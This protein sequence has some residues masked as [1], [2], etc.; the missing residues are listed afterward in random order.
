MPNFSDIID[1]RHL[2][3]KNEILTKLDGSEKIKF[4]VGYLYLSGFYQIADKLENLQ[5]VKLLIGSNINR[6]LMEALAESAAGDEELDEQFETTQL[7]RPID[8]D[9]IKENI[10]QSMTA[11]LQAL[12]HT[13][14]RQK[15][16][17]KLVELVKTRKVHIRVYTKHPLHAKAYI[18][19]FQDRIASASASEGIGIIGSSN[20]TMS[21]FFHNTELN[22]YV[23]G[24]KNYEELN[25]WF[26]R[27]WEEGV[28]FE[29]ALKETFEESWALKTVNPYDIFILTLYHLTKTTIER[30]TEQIWFWEN[31]DFMARLAAKFKK[32]KDLYSFQKVAI[33][34]AYQW[35]NQYS[36]VFISDVVGLGKT[37]IGAGLLKQL[38]RRA[39][40]IS[41]PGLVPMWEEFLE[42][43]EVDGKVVSRGLIRNGVYNKESCL[44]QY[45]E[46]YVVL[47]DESHHLRNNDTMLYREV[48][49][50][51]AGKKVILLTATPQNTS[52]WNIYNQIKL[53]NQ[54]EENI[55]PNRF[56]E[57]HL[58]NLFK[59]VEK[60]EYALPDLLKHFVIRR[61]RNHIKKFYSGGDFKIEFPTR[62]LKTCTYN[63]NDTY[64][65]LY[66]TIRQTLKKL[67]YAR[68]DL[69][70]YVN[71]GK[72]EIEP[73][74]QLKKVTG[75]LRVFHKIRM[76]KRLESSIYSF[77]KSV[78]NLLAI[79]EKFLVIIEKKNIIP[80]GEQ[81][82]DRIYRYDLDDIWDQIDDLAGEYK[83]EDFAIEALVEDLKHD[84]AVLKEIK[85]Y[86]ESIPKDQDVKYD[87]LLG[88][89][90]T[91]RNDKKQKK[92]LIFSE[93]A[94]TVDYLYD[95][96]KNTYEKIAKIHGGTEGN[97]HKI[98]SFAPVAND[99]EGPGVIHFM[100]ASDVLSEGHNLQ[101]CSAVVNY[102]LHWNPVRLIQR[103]GRVD[104]IGSEAET[105]YI[106]NF[107]PID[108]VEK[109]INLEKILKSRIEEIHDHIGEDGKILTQ[110]EQLNED[111][112]YAI[113]EQTDI[114]QIEAVET[115]TFSTEEAE[116][117]IKNL[118]HDSPEYMALIKKMQL[119]LRSAKAANLLSGSY[120]F[121]RSGEFVR[122]LIAQPNGSIEEDFTKIMSEIRCDADEPELQTSE[123]EISQYFDD[124]IKLRDHFSKLIS[125]ENRKTKIEPEVRKA[126]NRLREIVNKYPDNVEIKENAGKIDK[127]L[128]SYFPHHL[129]AEL[130][131][132]NKFEKD[133]DRW[134]EEL[135]NLYNK[136]SLGSAI[137]QEDEDAKKP[138]KFI[139]GEILK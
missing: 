102:D 18:F 27:L 83:T 122:L 92:L 124:I 14:Q 49:P 30:Q 47:I 12:P 66:D 101:D 132:L 44:W 89:I 10:N 125:T 4:A 45:Q 115:D 29:D 57:P 32:M 21:G 116:I 2:T 130:K 35:V 76:F 128:N 103:A 97:A 79:H 3:L 126:H 53:F 13:I 84:I 68:Y 91:L 56:E 67:K 15:E 123:D 50:F 100:V 99:Y 54:T 105:I 134:Y 114:E 121:F 90:E 127:I 131:R 25:E 78:D 75:T 72:K 95:R 37:Y 36:A 64:Q 51:L 42:K 41:P 52:V 59:K 111:A 82:Q 81:I 139:C 73:Y 60:N 63:I 135:V 33:M 8:R 55:F 87:A 39:L 133:D 138:I 24:Q 136:E 88:L 23:R 6:D 119:G 71:P 110:E 65:A 69:W 19:K 28:P 109:E 17:V 94:D 62:E 77:R 120:A 98:E 43:F 1:N 7:Q 40:I 129:I 118:Q 80:A 22:T 85:T 74:I 112:M 34:Q 106:N 108:E 9:R 117:I 113:Y 107:L 61:T 38:N 70:K 48:Q 93:Y 58:R 5:D 26:D 20:L 96:M 46:R 11:N 104:R 86:L 16:I 137:V 31:P